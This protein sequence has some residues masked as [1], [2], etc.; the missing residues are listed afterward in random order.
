MRYEIT[1]PLRG[2]LNCH[3]SMCRKAHGAAFRSRARVKSRDFRWLQGEELLTWYESSPGTHRGFC[4]VCGAKLL[5]RFDRHPSAYGLPLGALDGDPGV[6]P[7]LH[8]YVQYKAP[9]FEI[10]DGLPQ[11]AELPQ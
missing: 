1:G 8:L 9:W 6:R 2:A 3:C 7:A 5:S 11:H 4:R 10:S